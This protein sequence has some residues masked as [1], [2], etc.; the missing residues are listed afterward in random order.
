MLPITRPLKTA[1]KQRTILAA[2]LTPSQAI[3]SFKTEQGLRVE[4]AA[5][6]PAT[7]DPVAIAFD[8]QG[9]MFVVED[10]GYPTGPPA[11]QPPAGVVAMLEDT[12]GDGLY[13]KR[14][15]LADGL[16]F[17]NGIA[18]WRGGVFVTCAPN[19]YYLKD[20]QGTGR[21][22]VRKVVLTGF[23]DTTTTQLRVSHPTLGLDGWIYLTSGL[24]GGRVTSPEHPERSAV[25][26][27]KSD[28]RFKPDTLEFETVAG[29]GQFGMSFDEFGRRFVCSNRNPVQHVVL[30]TRYLK[31]NPY[32]RF[33]ETVQDVAPF[34]AD[35]KVWPISPDTTTASFIPELMSAPH[36]GTF[37]SACGLLIYRGEMLGADFSGN[38]FVCEPAQNLVQRQVLFPAGFFSG[39]TGSPGDRLFNF[40]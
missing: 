20:T 9:R 38:A 22:D 27:K 30:E 26:F 7:M 28:S 24:T 21:A 1:A 11:G 12:D 3:A 5:A 23:D 15:V 6:E 25:Q 4:L 19:V 17:P 33:S 37:T 14:T 32:L 34:G 13:D 39:S 8:E 2:P 36:A 40:P 35:A 18:C 31:R 29:A 10:R 16:T